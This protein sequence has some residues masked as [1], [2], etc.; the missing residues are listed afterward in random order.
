MISGAM[1]PFPDLL[2][3]VATIYIIGPGVLNLFMLNS[4]VHETC[5]AH[6]DEMSIII[7]ILIF[8]SIIN[9]TS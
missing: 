6:K 2:V 9:T 5:H 1:A 7:G 8:V 4:N 3:C